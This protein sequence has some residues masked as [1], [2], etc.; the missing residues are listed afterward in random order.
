MERSSCINL[1][2]CP[3]AGVRRISKGCHAIAK[4]CAAIAERP[5]RRDDKASWGKTGP[6]SIRT[7]ER[8]VNA[9]RYFPAR[10]RKARPLGMTMMMDERLARLQAHRSNIRRYDRLLKTRLSE[11]ERQFI[12]KRLSEERLAIAG[13]AASQ[14]PAIMSS[15]R[16]L[17]PD[18]RSTS[19][20]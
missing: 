10:K 20:L 7:H 17:S 6:A 13:L 11:V 19:S 15:Q 8:S 12:E 16:A 5:V 14:I 4:T 3:G 1:F 18:S 9:R 2:K